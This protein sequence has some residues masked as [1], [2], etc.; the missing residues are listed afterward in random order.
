MPTSTTKLD[1]EKLGDLGRCEWVLTNGLGGFAMGTVNGVPD[2]RYHGWLVGAMRPPVGRVMGLHSAIE[3]IALEEAGDEA[4]R[5]KRIELSSYRFS[6]GVIHPKGMHRLVQFEQ[7]AGWV[8]WAYLVD[9]EVTVTRELTLV[10]E[11]NTALVR[12]RVTGLRGRAWLEVKPLVGL[13]DYHALFRERAGYACEGGDGW[14][15]VTGPEEL[16]KKLWMSMARD[17]KEKAA[18]VCEPEWWRNFEYVREHERGMDFVEDLYSPGTFVL[19]CDHRNKPD[20]EVVFAA[21][22]DGAV[23]EVRFDEVVAGHKARVSVEG[24]PRGCAAELLARSTEMKTS[25][26]HDLAVV[27]EGADQFVVRRE[28]TKNTGR[29]TGATKGEDTGRETGATKGKGQSQT[30][31]VAGY[32]WFSD[33]GRD[34][35]ISMRGLLLCTG[36]Y[37]EALS[38]LRAFAGLQKNGLIPNCFDNAGHAEYNTV[39]ASLWYVH[40]ACEYLR[41]S[42]DR[43]GFESVLP[44]CLHVV[45]AYRRGTEFD[46]RMDRD[47]LI[48]AGCEGTQ[49]TWMDARRDGVVFTPRHGKA[50]EINALWYSG[51]LELAHAVDITDRA[52]AEELRECAARCA[53]SFGQFWNAGA[54]CL[55][56]VLTPDGDDWRP[57]ARVR[58]NQVFAVSQPYSVLTAQQKR[59]VLAKV[60]ERL[61]TPMGLR[62]LDPA[63]P[64]Y[65][66]RFE[67]PIRERDAAYHNGTVWPWLIGAYCEGVLRAAEFS[68]ASRDDVRG[69]IAP[70]LREFCERTAQV[71][72]IRQLAE[73][74]DAEEKP[75]HRRAEGCMA[76]AWSVAEVL[77]VMCLVEGEQDRARR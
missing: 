8:R 27:I 51:L 31:I 74:Y 34:T 61:L 70:L 35:F 50:V 37:D 72:P 58:P 57:D 73:V 63:D 21:S 33:W 46:I 15:E 30:S 17:G 36:R 41:V 76:Q 53:A 12:Y 54:S 48:T 38:V 44:A 55:F 20:S 68:H 40:A 23:P 11:R 5:G 28:G 42:G 56:D 45:D 25:R 77:R 16:G 10:R 39:D 13:R 62:T 22:L 60:K 19:E 26:W 32:P 14:C 2:R 59:A 24:L 6:G 52:K 65:R 69:V 71:G 18:F 66:P 43:V 9:D 49:L 3:W 75:G 4:V 7:G 29:E 1:I 67:G 47:G 64:G